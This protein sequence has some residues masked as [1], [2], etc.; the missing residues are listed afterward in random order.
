MNI[1]KVKVK[2]KWFLYRPGVAQRVGRGIALL[3]HDRG[4]RKGWMASVTPRPHFTPGK[5]SVPIAQEAGW[6]PGPV[7]TSAEN[8]VPT[9]IRSRTLNPVWINIY[10]IIVESP[11]VQ[12]HVC[13]STEC[14][15]TG[16]SCRSF[17]CCI[18][19][20]LTLHT[21]NV[22]ILHSRIGFLTLEDGTDR[23]S[24]NVAKAFPLLAA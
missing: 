13:S 20:Y 9:A 10:K 3:F 8:L 12:Q 23:L 5:D 15:Q 1:E 4:T 14:S 7:W 19:C 18:L 2:V 22:F 6:A 16:R 17:F 24:R 21:Q 11:Q